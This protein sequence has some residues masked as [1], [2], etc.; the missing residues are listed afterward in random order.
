MPAPLYKYSELRWARA[1]VNEGSIKVG[2]LSEYRSKEG[3]DQE[4]GDG[5]EGELTLPNIHIGP[6][7]LVVEGQG[8]VTVRS[9][10]PDL[11]IYCTS[12][13]YDINIGRAFT[14]GEPMGCVQINQPELF[15]LALDA[16]LRN[17]VKPNAITLSEPKW[18]RCVYEDRRHDWERENL[19]AIWL[20]KPAKFQR[21]SEIR[22]CWKP[23]PMQSLEFR[24]FKVPAIIPYCTLIYAESETA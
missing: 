19:P 22:V 24:I 9:R 11:F 13:T 4:R 3:H 1:L 18:E 16:A 8:A 7:A 14:N 20:L 6:G 15:F 23:A 5:H 12:E 21:Q 2:T 17:E 10:I